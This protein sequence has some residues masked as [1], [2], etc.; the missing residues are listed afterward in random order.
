MY[1][2]CWGDIM[3]FDFRQWVNYFNQNK[4]NLKHIEWNEPYILNS[5]EYYT[6]LRSIQQFQVGER[7]EGK[8]LI[9]SA[10]YSILNQ[11]RV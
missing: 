11:G 1:G 10:K 4:E 6:I 5:N 7:S 8:F 3:I 2:K 9:K